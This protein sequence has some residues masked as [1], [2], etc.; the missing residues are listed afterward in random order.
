LKVWAKT[1][2]SFKCFI[3]CTQWESSIPLGTYFILAES[4]PHKYRKSC[5][6]NVN[7]A[8]WMNTV[9][10]TACCMLHIRPQLGV[11]FLADSNSWNV[12]GTPSLRTV[13]KMLRVLSQMAS[14]N[15]LAQPSVRFQLGH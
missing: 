2:I 1:G 3:N 11:R 9:C 13:R 14:D 7:Y 6:I 8:V 5:V 12:N 4:M 10:H 15:V